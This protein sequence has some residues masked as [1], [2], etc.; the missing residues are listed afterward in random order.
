[1]TTPT[2]Q[3]S[4]AAHGNHPRER[5]PWQTASQ[6]SFNESQFQG[7]ELHLNFAPEH[8][9]GL[10]DATVQISPIASVKRH[11]TGC[12]GLLTESIY[13]PAES[14]IECRFKGHAHLLVMYDE[15][16]RR[17]GETS[18]D[19]LDPSTLRN[20]ADKLTF[21][22]AG[23]S[24]Q[25]W[26]KTS[27]PMRV[28][29]LYLDPTK[30]Q[31]LAGADTSYLPR[32]FFEDQVLWRTAAKLKD[33]I[34]R[35]QARGTPY[36]EALAVVLLHEVPRS[37]QDLFRNSP[38][39]RG[40]LATWQI[41]AVTTYLEG[42]V[43]E[44]VS[45]ATLAGLTRLSQHHFCRAFKKSFGIPPHQYHVQ[46]RIESAKVLLADRANSVTD[47]ALMLGYSQSSAFSV[48]FRKTTGRSP[49]EFRRDFT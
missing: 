15:G 44:Q 36:S 11:S 49:N 2:L 29:Y 24:Y 31:N 46:R 7:V 34:E 30:L 27:S 42:H 13:A 26:H 6:C 4:G 23:H 37:G 40:G 17:E 47:V 3:L 43:G 41:R 5:R 22:P 19:G 33:T 28:T 32:I 45:L 10:R 25:E 18:V 16:A 9:C 38:L 8:A 48:A 20:F 1:M 39:N 21:V 35:G 12:D 14:R